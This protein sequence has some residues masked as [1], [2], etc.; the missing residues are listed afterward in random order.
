MRKWLLFKL[1]GR[2]EKPQK[3]GKKKTVVFVD[4]LKRV[5]YNMYD[6]MK[7][8]GMHPVLQKSQDYE[9]LLT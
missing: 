7:N 5:W 6:F 3:N 8:G 4:F 9:K 1:S 2:G